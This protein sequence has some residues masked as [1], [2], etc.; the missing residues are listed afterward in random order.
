MRFFWFSAILV[1]GSNVVYHICQKSIPPS[2]HVIVSI[3]I[4]FLIAILASALFLIIFPPEESLISAVKKVGW[5]SV[6]RGLAII[7]IEIG[8]LLLYRS[9][10]HISLGPVFC[11]TVVFLFLIPVGLILFKEKMIPSNILGVVLAITGIYLIT[12]Q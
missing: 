1:I 6:V 12:R 9:G 11:N 10:W 2:A 3:L 7:G 5:A 8:Y 4:T